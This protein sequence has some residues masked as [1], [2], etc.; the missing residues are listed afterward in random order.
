MIL[1]T[2]GLILH[3]WEES[4]AEDVQMISKNEKLYYLPEN[5]EE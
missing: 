5:K 1:E 4:V 2:N 3:S